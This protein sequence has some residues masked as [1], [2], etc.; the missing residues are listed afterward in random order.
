MKPLK[1]YIDTVVF[2]DFLEG[3]KEKSIQFITN[4]LDDDDWI[5]YTS[6]FTLLE[7]IENKQ[8]MMHMMKLALDEHLTLNEIVRKR[9][10]RRL[11]EEP[12]KYAVDVVDRLF[13]NN[14]INIDTPKENVFSRAKQLQSKINISAKDVI[15][16]ATALENKCDFFITGDTD[17]IN[18]LKESRIINA[19]TPDKINKVINDECSLYDPKSKPEELRGI[20]VEI[21][22]G[23]GCGLHRRC[24]EC[25]KPTDKGACTEHGKVEAYYELCVQMTLYDGIM[26]YKLYL[27]KDKIEQFFD[28]TLDNAKKMAT[29]AL[30]QEVVLDFLERKLKSKYF[31]VKAIDKMDQWYVLSIKHDSE[32]TNKEIV[33]IHEKW[34]E[35]IN[36]TSQ[37]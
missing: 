24:N 35:L 25:G 1:F 34:L 17:L 4:L 2:L 28:V 18:T 30:D 16:V 22:R 11:S 26:E 14:K 31:V 29:E 5:G 27:D 6:W 33:K 8:V 19:T 20:V 23:Y 21:L 3:R 15:H 36:T 37:V 12:L 9:E 10:Q 13:K 7:L 32:I